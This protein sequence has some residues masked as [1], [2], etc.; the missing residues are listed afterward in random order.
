MLEK[1][2]KLINTNTYEEDESMWINELVQEEVSK[3]INSLRVNNLKGQEQLAKDVAKEIIEGILK[4]QQSIQKLM[5]EED[6]EYYYLK[7]KGILNE[8][9]ESNRESLEKERKEKDRI[10]ELL[11]EI[12]SQI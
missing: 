7:G 8:S 11:K 4:Y 9:Y 6:R 5:D 3:A 2:K 10:C 12:Y 1:I